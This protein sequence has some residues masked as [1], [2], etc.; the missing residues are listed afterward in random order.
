MDG[1]TETQGG[2]GNLHASNRE[3]ARIPESHLFP[4]HWPL[5][6]GLGARLQEMKDK[7]D[8][9]YFSLSAYRLN[10]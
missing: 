6:N 5:S 7:E 4:P 9:F 10:A 3:R 8:I 2:N 1:E